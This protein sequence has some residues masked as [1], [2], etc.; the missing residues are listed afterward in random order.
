MV[1]SRPAITGDADGVLLWWDTVSGR[2]ERSV[3]AHD[4][5]VR[6]LHVVGAHVLSG[7]D[8]AIVRA[9]ALG[10]GVP[11]FEI[12]GAHEHSVVSISGTED[13]FFAASRETVRMFDL[14]TAR[15]DPHRHVAKLAKNDKAASPKGS[16]NRFIR[17]GKALF[18]SGL[19]D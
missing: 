9:W 18:N 15:G 6:A 10:T 19:D 13:F 11:L 7:G 3:T 2:C 5:T 16:E 1:A 12:R 17:M 8:D 4:G 14:R